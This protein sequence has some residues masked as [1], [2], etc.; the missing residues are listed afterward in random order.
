MIFGFSRGEEEGMDGLELAGKRLFCLS[1]ARYT[2]DLL[3][4]TMTLLLG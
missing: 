4:S 1:I 3:L 2:W